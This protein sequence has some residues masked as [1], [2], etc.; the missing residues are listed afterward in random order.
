MK[1]LRNSDEFKAYFA[2]Q[3]K[4]YTVAPDNKQSDV[5]RNC[6]HTVGV[7]DDIEFEVPKFQEYGRIELFGQ[8]CTEVQ[9][10]KKLNNQ[11]KKI[12]L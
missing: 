3:K 7:V 10:Q 8:K 12:T 9:N 6:M 4:I 1:N 2:E 11:N 5:A